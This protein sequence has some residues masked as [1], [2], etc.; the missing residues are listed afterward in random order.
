NPHELEM[1]CLAARLGL[2]SR[3]RFVDWV[4]EDELEALYRASSCFVL[5][6][7]IEGFGLP[8]LEAMARRVPVACSNRPA[9]PEVAGDAALF[10]DPEDHSA[11]A[12]C[13]RRLLGESALATELVERG[14]ERVRSFSWRR[15][16]EATLASYH[17]AI[18]GR[19]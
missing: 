18:A 4:S 8:V 5:P 12:A 6:S 14:V 10:F 15:T 17:R 3:V 19:H 2:E 16:A 13:I 9:L 7:L 11:I 1:R